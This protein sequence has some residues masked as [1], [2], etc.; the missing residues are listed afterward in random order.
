LMN[1]ADESDIPCEYPRKVFL[2]DR[3]RQDK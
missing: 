2:Y 1:E 3:E